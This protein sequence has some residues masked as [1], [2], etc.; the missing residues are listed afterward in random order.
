M[1][2]YHFARKNRTLCAWLRFLRRDVDWI[3]AMVTDD[4]TGRTIAM[5]W[6]D[7]LGAWYLAFDAAGRAKRSAV[8]DELYGCDEA[9]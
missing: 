3:T 6:D 1:T 7:E 2:G 5:A 9:A 4:D 8:M